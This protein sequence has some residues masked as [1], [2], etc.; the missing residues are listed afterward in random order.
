MPRNKSQEGF[1]DSMR[2]RETGPRIDRLESEA[3][4]TLVTGTT[5]LDVAP[6]TTTTLTNAFCTVESTVVLSPTAALSAAEVP[7]LYWVPGNG[8]ITITHTANAGAR[9]FDY[10]IL[11][12]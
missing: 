5:T 2:E 9:P 11:Q 12:R 10:A 1:A 7:T 8:S 4:F 3:R 6:A